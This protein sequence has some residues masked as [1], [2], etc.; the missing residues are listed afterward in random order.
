MDDVEHHQKS[1]IPPASKKAFPVAP[2]QKKSSNDNDLVEQQ[3]KFVPKRVQNEQI[4][5]LR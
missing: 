5:N 2:S 4:M 1:K 3:V